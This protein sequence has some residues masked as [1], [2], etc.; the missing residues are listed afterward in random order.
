MAN[1]TAAITAEKIRNGGFESGDLAGW[2]ALGRAAVAMD[3][4]SAHAGKFYAKLGGAR[5]G[6]TQVVR[7]LTPN[8]TYTLVGYAR[9]QNA[10][11]HVFLG[12]QDHGGDP[13]RRV[14]DATH[15]A[16]IALRFVTG[17]KNTTAT[18]AFT[19]DNG[20][21]DV[22][23]DD[24]S[25]VEGLNDLDVIDSWLFTQSCWNA[26][27]RRLLEVLQP[28]VLHRAGFFWVGTAL[29]DRNYEG[30]RDSLARLQ[31]AGSR[32]S[33][34]LGAG[35]SGLYWEPD[36][37][38]L[39]PGVDKEKATD[40]PAP[41]RKEV[42]Q[43]A[44]RGYLPRDAENQ[45]IYKAKKQIDAG[46][47][48]IE[49]DELC[50]SESLVSALHDYAQTRYGRKVFVT[51]N[52]INLRWGQVDYGMVRFYAFKDARGNFD[53]QINPA[54]AEKNCWI[55]GDKDLTYFWFVDGPG[56][57]W[58]APDSVQYPN[59]LR[60][61]GAWT[62]AAGNHRPGW[63]RTFLN[64]TDP[65][66]PG[67]INSGVFN[68]DAN[69][70]KFIKENSVLWHNLAPVAPATFAVERGGKIWKTAYT[71]PMRTI[72]HL[73]NGNYDN[74]AHR[75]PV[76]SELSLRVSLAVPPRSIWMTT[77][78]RLST[79]RR[80]SLAFT[81][82]GGIVTVA[83]PQLYFHDI[84]VIEQGPPNTAYTPAYDAMRVV[85]PFPLRRNLPVF[86]TTHI[87][88]IQTEGYSPRYDWRVNGVAGGSPEAGTISAD[89]DYTAPATVPPGGRVAIQAVSRDDPA[90]AA[91]WEIAI[92]KALPETW[93][94]SFG[95]DRP[96]QMPRGW[97]V[98]DG[99][100]DW[101]VARDGSAKVLHNSNLMD[102]IAEFSSATDFSAA[103]GHG[104]DAMIVGGD[105]RWQDYRYS[106]EFKA[107]REPAQWYSQASRFRYGVFLVWRYQDHDN[108]YAYQLCT[109]DQVR[110][111]RSLGGRKTQ[112]NQA[113]ACRFPAVGRY[114]KVQ[115]TADGA[116]F[117]LQV[118][119]KIIRTDTDPSLPSGGIGLATRFTENYFRNIG[120]AP[121]AKR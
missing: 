112:I 20:T 75:M 95:A 76:T 96:G 49:F 100:G 111:F 22:F 118:R 113:V 43:F 18:I 84:I 77:P 114:T 74:R 36:V 5:A 115:I 35:V 9:L 17:P 108:Y 48:D 34:V 110:M 19:K 105:Q 101:E 119:G 27:D 69:M 10:G 57:N 50:P 78:D 92:G 56:V 7:G 29:M 13:V 1:G 40:S 70:I 41:R 15:Y 2:K 81:Y 62:L 45:L 86:N 93:S 91:A 46:F 42:D 107:V 37:E 79:Q 64:C 16:K 94:E 72:V 90:A 30:A 120:V 12:V 6:L 39:G 8:T 58:L 28:D 21:G 99:Q 109:D 3:P 47:F 82:E 31:N 61:I 51:A 104:T 83:I 87:T 54:A 106:V 98:V 85:F 14:S 25:V 60:L 24:F 32:S 11:E 63:S 53:G 52:P 55:P 66:I 80:Q 44:G 38:T 33:R 88:A 89:G 121:L 73:V 103:Q 23:G 102:G 26:R 68:L 97:E 117:T 4:S 67:N 65:L 59:A 116:R 71:Q